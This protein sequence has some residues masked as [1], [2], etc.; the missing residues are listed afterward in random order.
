M[1]QG[2]LPM[3]TCLFLNLS[4]DSWWQ[5]HVKRLLTAWR[6]GGQIEPHGD[7]CTPYLSPTPPDCDSAEGYGHW[8]GQS[9]L[10]LIISAPLQT[11]PEKPRGVFRSSGH[12]PVHKP[13]CL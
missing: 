4:R 3:V 9:L 2:F 5:C 8:L 12:F 1:F 7:A 6:A 13:T 10:D 11:Y